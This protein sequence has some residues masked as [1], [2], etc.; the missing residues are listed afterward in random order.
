MCDIRNEIIK[1]ISNP[2]VVQRREPC[3]VDLR[4]SQQC[5]SVRYP[6][7][8]RA[9]AL[10][11]PSGAES[12]LLVDSDD[13]DELVQ[14]R[15]QAY[16]ILSSNLQTLRRLQ[17]RYPLALER[18]L[19]SVK[20][21]MRESDVTHEITPVLYQRILLQ[22][23]KQYVLVRN[24]APLQNQ[25]TALS[26]AN[27]KLLATDPDLSLLESLS[28]IATESHPSNPSPIEMATDPTYF[29]DLEPLTLLPVPITKRTD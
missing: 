18:P 13:I 19:Q 6:I 1:C 11:R 15:Q 26:E 21:S 25:I 22:P 12:L 2:G 4:S 23:S 17:L 28:P 29:D 24:T 16:D 10:N 7:S 9:R 3:R 27:D 8:Q 20:A 14:Q 5:T